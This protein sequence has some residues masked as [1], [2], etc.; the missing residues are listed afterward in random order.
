MPV[1]FYLLKTLPS[2]K[3][4]QNLSV[5]VSFDWKIGCSFPKKKPLGGVD[6]GKPL[7]RK[8]EFVFYDR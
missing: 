4:V 8:K 5:E 7:L 3:E 6:N 2:E 1:T